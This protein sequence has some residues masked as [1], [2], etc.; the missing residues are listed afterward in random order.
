MRITGFQNTI[1]RK[2]ILTVVLLTLVTSFPPRIASA[3]PTLCGTVLDGKTHKPIAYVTIILDGVEVRISAQDGSF[4]FGSVKDGNHVITFKH[5]SYSRRSISIQW[6]SDRVPL[7]VEL[8]PLLY[9]MEEIVVKGERLPIGSASFSRRELTTAPGNFANDPLRTLQSQP[10]CATDGIDFLSKMAVRGGDT[11]EHL[12]YFDGYPLN[13]YANVGGFSGVVYDDMLESTVLIP[14]AAPIQYTGNLS[15]IVLLTPERPDTSFIS[16]RY[17]ITSMAGGI[18]QVVTSSLSFQASAKTSFFNLPVYQEIGVQKRSFKDFLGRVMLSP[19]KSITLTT[20][21][22][23]ATDSETGNAPE[24]V[25]LKREVSS[26]LA[27]VQ[28]SY[29]SSG[30]EI[31][32]RPAYSFYDSRDALSWRQHDRTHQLQETRL[33][34]EM[35]RGGSALG[36]GLSGEVGMV[37]HS[38][39]GGEWRD[40]PFSTSVEFR[41]ML[42][43][44]ASL[45]LAIGGSQEPWTSSFDPEAYG[46]VQ[47][48]MG[49]QA[50]ISAGY[51][52]SHQSPFRFTERRYFASLPIDAGDLLS[53]Y[54]PSWEKTPAV[55]MDQTSIGATV[56][57]PYRFS[58]ECNG[59]QRWYNNLLTWEWE[60]FPGFDN[61]SSN[62][63]GHG[64]G[65]EII[66][67][68]NDP[69]FVSVMV[70]SARARV[71]KREGTLMEERVGDFDRPNSWQFNLSAKISD[72]FRFSLRLM[73]IDGRPYT[74]Y[75]FQSVP[76]TTDEVNSVR[77]PRFRRLDVKLVY[78]IHHRSF[79]AEFFLDVV[80]VLDRGNIAMMYA[81]EISPGEFLSLPYGGTTLFPIGGVTI[82]W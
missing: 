39:S 80:N 82:R 76:P 22:L 1:I 77:L 11:E 56:T 72:S 62:G 36:L 18:S 68:R 73:D 53:S 26:M 29:R 50:R 43:D 24:G 23:M 15:G 60:D 3:E 67:A 81:L 59:F 57:L 33:H 30:W 40:N 41:L 65:Y 16:F 13:H 17:D 38:G 70:A 34:A 79:D 10:S 4:D 7:L 49:D 71:W 32:L 35:T 66:L 21:L 9:T 55:Q 64:F 14:G 51:R 48:D 42:R 2:R 54:T 20:T 37:R 58:L 63:E 45:V 28:L 6:P 52:R 46:S 27:G 5:I 12:V 69:D 78:G 61:V 75:D 19:G 74:P 47:I 44:F 31:N 8:D 25:Q